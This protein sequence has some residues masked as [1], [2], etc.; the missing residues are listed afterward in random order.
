MKRQWTAEEANSWYE[1][2][3]WLRGCNFIGS[4]C[5][6]RLDMW[7]SYKS[8]EKLATADRELALA[9]K[10]GFNTVRLWANFDVYYEE[11]DSFMEILEQ[12]LL[13][14]HKH[15]QKVMLVLGY[16]EDLPRGDV[17][18]PKKLGEQAYAMGYHQG[19][20]PMTD[21]YK[22]LEPHH[23]MEYPE[24]KDKFVEMVTRIVRKYRSDDRI[25]CWNVWN[26]PG[27]ERGELA[28]E[29]LE[30][31]FKAVRAEDPIQPLC[32]D[33]W[34]GFDKGVTKTKEEAYALEQSDVI[35]FHSYSEYRWFVENISELKKLNRPIFVT[36][37]L[38]RINHNNVAEIY[39]LLYIE[40]VA[41][42]CWGFVIGKTQTNEPWDY[43]WE[44]VD[45]GEGQN[46][47]FTKWQ[48][49]LFRPNLRPYDPKEIELITY[50]N[51]LADNR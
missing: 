24:L 9:K 3:G 34:R 48:H 38:H 16:E 31:L 30:I 36:E 50:F 45:K 51:K 43:M 42:Y 26:E 15:G 29:F 41:N 1:K 10:I 4:D 22:A 5:A 6:N 28:I 32:A 37:W 39:P 25:F 33:V 40:N 23:Y 13:L 18:V 8:E 47:D 11:P 44:L 19:R 17:F 35:S 12:Y 27:I 21:E 2:L 49:D 7:Q 20:F 14:C 46:L